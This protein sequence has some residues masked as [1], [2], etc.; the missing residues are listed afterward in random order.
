MEIFIS[1]LKV[2]KGILLGSLM[3]FAALYVAVRVFFILFPPNRSLLT[4][5]FDF[6]TIPMIFGLAA[7]I[8]FLMFGGAT[9]VIASRLFQSEPQLIISLEGIKDKRLNFGLIEWNE[10]ETISLEETK[11]AQWLNLRLKSPENYLYR[12]PGFQKFLRKAN[13]QH[14]FNNFRIRFSDLDTPID[15]AWNFIEENIIKPR[16][17]QGIT[18][19]P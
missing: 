9:I 16:T 15:E 5:S 2:V 12:L 1:K 10:I 4:S 3:T 6:Q 7:V 17:E 8:G 13:G 18:L 19:K 11:Y 14:E